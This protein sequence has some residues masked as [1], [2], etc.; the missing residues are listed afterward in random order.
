MKLEIVIGIY[1]GS[2]I[3]ANGIS[4][5]K[6]ILLVKLV[7]KAKSIG[8]RNSFPFKNSWAE[9]QPISNMFTP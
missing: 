6:A 3:N 1:S 7:F 4:I 5:N 9:Y 2:F 8:S